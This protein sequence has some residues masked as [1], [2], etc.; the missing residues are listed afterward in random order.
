MRLLLLDLDD[1]LVDDRSAVRTA[2]ASFLAFHGPALQDVE[3]PLRLWRETSQR[4]WAR[5]ERGEATFQE[6]R[7]AR[8]RDFLGQPFT[9]AEADA[10]FEPY[11]QA[12]QSAWKLFPDVPAFLARTTAL[13]KVVIT[14][15]EREQQ[16]LKVRAVGLAPHIA[17]V[18][19]PQDCG[20]WK[21]DPRIF[22][23]ALLRFNA[24]PSASFMIGD[25]ETRDIEPAARLGLRTFRVDARDPER[26]L[27]KAL[28]DFS[29]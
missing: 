15:G 7:R 9:D 18:I 27:R 8:M 12:Y 2:F 17:E 24:T 21:P 6:Q 4:H 13:T 29:L 23:E 1:T 26:T 16:R 20:A 22:M 5:F 19:T 10:A 14:N 3:D 25:D 28:D 11:R